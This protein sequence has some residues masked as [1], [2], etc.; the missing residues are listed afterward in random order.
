[1]W[2]KVEKLLRIDYESKPAYGDCGQCDYRFS[3]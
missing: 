1:M 2:E 3:W